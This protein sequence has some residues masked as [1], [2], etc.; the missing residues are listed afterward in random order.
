MNTCPLISKQTI[1]QRRLLFLRLHHLQQS[2]RNRGQGRDAPPIFFGRN[3]KEDLVYQMAFFHYLLPSPQ[4]FRPSYG[5]YA[6]ELTIEGHNDRS[7]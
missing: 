6:S 4:I 7:H 1:V 3:K 5:P 2:R